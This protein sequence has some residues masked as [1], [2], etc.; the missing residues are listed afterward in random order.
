VKPFTKEGKV[1][2][3]QHISGDSVPAVVS[4]NEDP[5]E[6]KGDLQRQQ[7]VMLAIGGSDTCAGAGI[8]R[9]LLTA[10][11]FGVRCLT[12]IACLTS[13]SDEEFFAL[14][15]VPAPFVQQQIRDMLAHYPVGIIKTGALGDAKVVQAVA[16]AIGS[17]PVPVV[18]DPVLGSSA[19]GS[20][21]G[22]ELA[23]AYRRYLLPRTWLLTPNESELEQLGGLDALF[24]AGTAYVLVTGGDSP[25]VVD[26]LFSPHGLVRE[27]HH[28]KLPFRLHGTGCRL[29]SALAA[30]TLTGHSLPDAAGQA[31]E[32]VRKHIRQHGVPTSDER[33]FDAEKEKR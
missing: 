11:R 25:Q 1:A 20:F 30:L 31:M 18:V 29:A 33:L 2:K 26:R 16:Q 17:S 9:D 13:Q 19:A 32:F 23:L 5:N 15:R 3:K 28:E 12:A 8:Q 21:A 22:P 10:N 6:N 14:T 27:F 4:P 7:P 24:A